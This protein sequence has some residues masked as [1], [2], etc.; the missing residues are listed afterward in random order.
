[1]TDLSDLE[2]AILTGDAKLALTAAHEALGRGAHPV[3][4]VTA[5]I[6]PAMDEAGRRFEA[7]DYFVPELLMA[8]RAT[9]GVFDLI[10]PLLAETGAEPAGRVVLGTVQG[11]LHDIGKNLVKTMLEGG[12]FEVVDL[13]VDVPAD[14]FVA[15]VADRQPGILALSALLTTTM[16]G[17]KTTLQALSAAGLRQRV[18]VMV[19]GA[20]VTQAFADAI[21]ADGYRPNAASVVEL[22]RQLVGG[23]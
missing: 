21:G 17:M 15:A 12:G 20:P 22:A 13:G 1:V 10:R 16:P 4:L 6:S 11:D 18:K 2:T 5:A 9:K 3:E 7:G 19:G 14:K 23:A 8:A